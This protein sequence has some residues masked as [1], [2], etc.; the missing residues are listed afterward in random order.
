ML[1]LLM[2][3]ITLGHFLKKSQHKY[4]QEAGLTTLIGMLAGLLLKGVKATKLNKQLSTHFI[5]LFLILLLPPIIF[6]SGYNLDKRP[7]FKNIG[8]VLL[9]SFI[10]T[11]VAIFS[12]SLMLYYGGLFLPTNL[13]P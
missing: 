3:A 5:N 7:F 10:G 2:G 11:F 12:T 4:L 6:D 13:S 1:A 9:Y 8:S